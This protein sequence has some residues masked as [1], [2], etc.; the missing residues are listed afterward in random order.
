MCATKDE[1][2]ICTFMSCNGFLHTRQIIVSGTQG[3]SGQKDFLQN[4]Q[5]ILPC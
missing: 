5:A 3:L 1:T 4:I 2:N